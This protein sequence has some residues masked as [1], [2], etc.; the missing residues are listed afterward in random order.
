ME[1]FKTITILALM[2]M[3]LGSILV[4]VA[5]AQQME[6]PVQMPPVPEIEIT[7]IQ[8]SDTDAIE[9][10]DVT[11]S[12]TI[13]NMNSTMA[14][15][16]ITLSLYLDYDVAHNFTDISLDGGES[17]THEYVWNSESGTHNVTAMLVLGEMPLP[18][19]QVSEELE[20]GLGDV[21][22]VVLALVILALAVLVIAVLPSLFA[23]MR[24]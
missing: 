8:F 17:S 19:T 9:G 12:I 6:P 3:L 16:N 7:E 18:D 23:V 15:E 2:V 13:E 4:P 1:K 20:I 21:G 5:S 14:V 10:Q 24:K 11:I 22:T